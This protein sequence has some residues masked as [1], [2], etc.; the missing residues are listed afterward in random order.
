MGVAR[1]TL[2]ATLAAVLLLL[3]W[4]VS[5]QVGYDRLLKAASEPRNWLMYSGTYLS[6][7]YSQ[8]RQID[9][10][11][12]KNLEQKWLYQSPVIGNWESTPLVVDGIM[13]VTQRPN[14]VIALDAKPGACSG[15]T[16]ITL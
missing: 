2:F 7:R 14:N 4:R 12:V 13:Y 3:T 5:A 8:L 15:F 6:Q 9:P 11:N 1:R 16:A 10:A